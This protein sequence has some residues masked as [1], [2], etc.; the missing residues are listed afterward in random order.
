MQ[1]P[2]EQKSAA[3]TLEAKAADGGGG[4]DEDTGAAAGADDGEGNA[5][6][7]TADS[8]D[9]ALIAAAQA[10]LAAAESRNRGLQPSEVLDIDYHYTE[11]EDFGQWDWCVAFD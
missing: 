9:A 2:T 5:A 7:A 10:E 8:T 11:D 1:Q 3:D 6:A 4:N